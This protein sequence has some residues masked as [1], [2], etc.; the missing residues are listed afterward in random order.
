MN[1]V[2]T[3]TATREIVIDTLFPHAPEKVWKTLT[4]AEL[5]A[6]WLKMPMTGFA[7][8]KGNRF[9][10]RTT[11]AGKWDGIIHCEVLDAVPNERLVYSWKGGHADNVGYGAPLETVVAW[12]LA[13][14]ANGTR[15]RIVHS[16]F[17]L[18]RNETAFT[19]MGNGWKKVVATIET[20]TAEQMQ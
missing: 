10:Y 9:T 17:V 20:V 5:I 13:R 12:T 14:E 2:A 11:P 1:D 15:V 19:N 4:T 7:P 8:V 16:G 6:R 3:K 18:P